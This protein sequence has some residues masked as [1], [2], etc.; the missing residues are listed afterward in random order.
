MKLDFQRALTRWTPGFILFRRGHNAVF[1]FWR[2]HDA[3]FG[4]E[5]IP[6]KH[7]CHMVHTCG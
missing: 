1:L 4:G 7:R 6:R 2:G 3:V 5:F